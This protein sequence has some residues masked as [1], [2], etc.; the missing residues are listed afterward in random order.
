MASSS[1]EKC[2]QQ[3]TATDALG[4]KRMT[5]IVGNNCEEPAVAD[6][7]DDDQ[8]TTS[9]SHDVDDAIAF[10]PGLGKTLTT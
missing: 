6:Y 1:A 10:G 7:V 4:C 9:S 8:T 5:E 3:L 2:L